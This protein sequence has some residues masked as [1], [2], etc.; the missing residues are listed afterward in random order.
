MNE[1]VFAAPALAATLS[2]ITVWLLRRG[3][4]ALP[5]DIPNA[6]SLHA[7]PVPRAGGYAVWLGFLAAAIA[8]APAYPGGWIGWLLC[9][10]HGGMG[11]SPS[12]SRLFGPLG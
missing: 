5:R 3:A 12:W 10:H 1:A 6:R 9:R 7:R 8:F 4:F 11:Q 2:A